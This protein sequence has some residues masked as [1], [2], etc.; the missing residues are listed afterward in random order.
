MTSI[1]KPKISII[2]VSF[3]GAST[4]AETIEHVLNQSYDNYDYTIIDGASSDNTVEIAQS[5]KDKFSEKGISYEIVSE[6]DNG[7]Y[8][9]MNKGIALTNGD[10]VGIINS[11]DY[12][13]D[14]AL[15]KVA[16]FYADTSFDAMYSDLRI[17]GNGKDFIKK[18]KL[19]KKKF[20]TRHWNHPT[21]FVTRRV[22]N[23]IKYACQSNNDD[24]N[25]ILSIRNKGYKIA[26]LNEVLANFR[27]GGVS[28]K[29]QKRSFSDFRAKLKLRNQIYKQN[30]CKGYKL[31]NFLTEFVKYI[32]S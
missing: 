32:L 7:I 17:F 20:T 8:D 25:F 19:D 24:L 13:N 2:T 29:K 1:A 3:N 26:V 14:D 5:Y 22:Y 30:G 10:I 6:K 12:Y 16:K 28:N 9:A 21:M 15:E 23:D 31:D 4:I 11:D 18:A 27:L